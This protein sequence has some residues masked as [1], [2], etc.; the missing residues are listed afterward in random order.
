MRNGTVVGKR[1]GQWLTSQMPAPAEA[2]AASHPP[3][4]RMSAVAGSALVAALCGVL[5]AAF[6]NS[7]SSSLLAR[8]A[9]VTG[10]GVLG[11]AVGRIWGAV[12]GVVAGVIVAAALAVL[13][14]SPAG[15][16]FLIAGC[17]AVGAWLQWSYNAGTRSRPTGW[18]RC[19]GQDEGRS[20]LESPAARGS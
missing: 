18:A 15:V 2:T 11:G 5:L 4:S 8:A 20:T 13:G 10:G 14:G 17:A 12:I 7:V 1:R 6:A 3:Q 16:V 9:V 19:R